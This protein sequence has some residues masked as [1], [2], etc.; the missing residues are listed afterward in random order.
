MAKEWLDARV[1]G[2]RLGGLRLC[3]SYAYLLRTLYRSSL[4]H[5]CLH[6]SFDGSTY[7]RLAYLRCRF[8]IAFVT[9]PLHLDF[10]FKR[11]SILSYKKDI[12][13]SM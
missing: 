9:G 10:F 8:K 12:V 2:V 5:V 13:S 4:V 7:R 11:A 6:T 1:Y 3:T